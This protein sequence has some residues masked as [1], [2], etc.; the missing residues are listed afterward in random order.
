MRDSFRILFESKRDWDIYEESLDHIRKTIEGTE[1]LK[2]AL[3]DLCGG[4]YEKAKEVVDEI[5]LLEKRSRKVAMRIRSRI[6][7]SIRDPYNREDLLKFIQSLEDIMR[8]VKATAHRLEMC[9]RFE[10]PEI[11][12]DD[13][14]KLV[15][16]VVLTVKSLEK[17]L[18]GMPYYPEDALKRTENISGHEEKVDEVRRGLMRDFVCIGDEMKLTQFY[19]L[20]EIFDNLEEI[21]DR[22]EK[23]GL[24][25]EL[26]VMS[27]EY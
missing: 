7:E 2:E 20:R 13:L 1:L 9:E 15:D 16:S 10:I 27:S 6:I 21:A 17:S 22:C 23:T 3:A 4:S 24:L 5:M 26:I 14:C 8:A 19:L 11:L 18:L 12:K 25:V